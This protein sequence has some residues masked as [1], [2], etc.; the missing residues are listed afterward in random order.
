MY[1][2]VAG[3]R[4]TQ[5]S[6]ACMRGGHGGCQL[7]GSCSTGEGA[8]SGVPTRY[9][10]VGAARGCGEMNRTVGFCSNLGGLGWA[11][12]ARA[13][14]RPAG[15]RSGARGCSCS[16]AKHPTR[17]ISGRRNGTPQQSVGG[18]HKLPQRRVSG[19]R[20]RGQSWWRRPARAA[21]GAPRCGTQS[22][23]CARCAAAGSGAQDKD[24]VGQGQ[25]SQQGPK[26]G[27]VR[28]E[29]GKR[30]GKGTPRRSAAGAAFPSSPERPARP[31]RRQRRPRTASCCLRNPGGGDRASSRGGGAWEV[32]RGGLCCTAARL[33][34]HTSSLLRQ[35]PCATEAAHHPHQ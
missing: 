28:V 29:R 35:E 25:M 7:A 3:K 19:R 21:R 12:A 18:G 26:R 15:C 14:V 33:Q 5:G 6:G 9:W 4:Y 31:W 2:V 20:G 16:T 11:E 8:G 23:S 10:G 27:R 13:E 34:P 30:P 1:T 17:G 32:R 24:K 22:P